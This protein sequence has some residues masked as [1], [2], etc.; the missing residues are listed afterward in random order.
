MRQKRQK[1]WRALLCPLFILTLFL[2]G[3]GQGAA[4]ASPPP[5]SGTAQQPSSV[6]LQASA[7]PADAK[8]PAAARSDGAPEDFVLTL[9]ADQTS[10]LL[11]GEK[12]VLSSAPYV[13]GSSFY[14]PLEDVVSLLGGSFVLQGDTA[15]VQLF[16]H[17]VSFQVG[18]AVMEVDGGT[19]EMPGTREGFRIPRGEEPIAVGENYGP[20]L[21]DGVFYVPSDLLSIS[22][23]FFGLNSIREYPQ[24]DMIILGSLQWEFGVD[25]IRLEDVFS[26]LPEEVKSQYE[27]VGPIDRVLNYSIVEYRSETTRVHVMRVDEGTED[28]EQ[29]DGRICT[30][31]VD[32]PGPRTPRGLQVR[33]GVDRAWLLYGYASM[34]DHFRYTVSGNWIESISFVTR[35]SPQQYVSP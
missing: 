35:Y 17:S 31:S 29:M 27:L 15:S 22:C 20:V 3:C 4:P 23:P 30:I 9:I 10:A 6:P 19:Y 21:A 28:V 16:D 26:D 33:D 7:A 8:A 24:T 34:A 5:A 12:A 25:S 32:R 14:I 2:T 13:S 11:N 18:R 1:L